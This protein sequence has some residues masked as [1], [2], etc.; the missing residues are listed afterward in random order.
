MRNQDQFHSVAVTFLSFFFILLSC[1][2]INAQAA[3]KNRLRVKADYIKIMD[4]VSLIE[5]STTARIDKKNT[6]VPN[7]ELS[8][9]HETEND[10]ILL[11][12]AKTDMNGIGRFVIKELNAIRPDSSGI[13]NLSASFEGNDK[14]KKASRSVSFKNCNI[15]ADL[16]IKDSLNFINARLTDAIDQ[17]PISE[18]LLS[19]R[20]VRLFRSLSLGEEFISTDDNGTILVPVEEGIPGIDGN[21]NIE[22]ILE[23]SDDYGTVKAFVMAPVGEP[24]VEESTFDER[25]MWSPRNKTPLFLLIFPNLLILAMW[26]LIAYLFFNLFKIYKSKI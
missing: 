20:V 4:S 22:V 19:V 12:K 21:L 2:Y 15:A 11:G 5:L 13:Y 3:E 25:T 14:F 10:E 16:I 7:I 6:T 26:G 24:I 9:F 17:V 8:I 23:D 1:Q 18:Q